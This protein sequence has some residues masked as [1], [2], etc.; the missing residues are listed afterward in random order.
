MGGIEVDLEETMAEPEHSDR[1]RVW[2]AEKFRWRKHTQL[3]RVI[4]VFAYDSRRKKWGFFNLGRLK[5]VPDYIRP[6]RPM[7]REEREAPFDTYCF[8]RKRKLR[9]HFFARCEP[10]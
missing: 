10:G 3:Y 9:L 6:E 4:W 1:D 8:K 5:L 7:T 2:P